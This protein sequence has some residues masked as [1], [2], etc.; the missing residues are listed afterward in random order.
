MSKSAGVVV[1]VLGFAA[2]TLAGCGQAVQ[3]NGSVTGKASPCV[4]PPA[5]GFNPDTFRYIVSIY[6]GTRMVAQ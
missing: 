4:G 5:P 6:Q 2:L 1:G 3:T